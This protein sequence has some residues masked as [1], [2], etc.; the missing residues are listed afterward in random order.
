MTVDFP[1]PPRKS[2][3]NLAHFKEN[4]HRYHDVVCDYENDGTPVLQCIDCGSRNVKSMPLVT[5]DEKI[6]P[7]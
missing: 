1:K 3:L 6:D 4:C 2:E 7:A 5:V